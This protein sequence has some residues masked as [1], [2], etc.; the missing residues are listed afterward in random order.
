MKIIEFMTEVYN[1]TDSDQDKYKKSCDTLKGGNPEIE[2]NGKVATTMFPTLSVINA[3]KAWGANLLIVHEPTYYDHWDS[4][5]NFEKQTGF[6]R[7]ILDMKRDFIENSG[8]VIYRYHDHPHYAE[9]DLIALGE[10][11]QFGL[12]G[13]WIN[14]EEIGC[15]EFELDEAMN[16]RDIAKTLEKSLD[17]AH[18]RICGCNNFM[19]KRIGLNFGT[20]GHI[21]DKMLHC[22]LI[23]TGEIVEWIHAEFVRDAT[24]L[25]I[26]RAIIVMGHTCSERE[27]MR[28]LA[29]IIPQKISGV[30][31]KYF[32]SGDAYTFT[33]QF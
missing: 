9:E 23:L 7:K 4:M 29:N 32:E 13:R 12:K 28:L 20:P 30:E 17:I 3:A 26:P 5:E 1:F 22:Q 14:S 10:I 18:V 11:S 24:E 16:V 27:G 8:L 21:E 25:G 15:S 31:S 6:K 33:D 2:F 19:V